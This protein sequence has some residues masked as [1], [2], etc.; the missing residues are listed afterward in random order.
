V[1]HHH[2]TGW[3]EAGDDVFAEGVVY[4]G[5]DHPAYGFLCNARVT[6]AGIERYVAF[7]TTLVAARH[8]VRR[9]HLEDAGLLEGFI[10]RLGSGCTA[11]AL[12][13]LHDDVELDMSDPAAIGHRITA[14]DKQSLVQSLESWPED[15]TVEILSS[16][17]D[18][19]ELYAEARV[20][21]TR[22][23]PDLTV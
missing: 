3:A 23:R 18:G 14:S 9:P 15:A 5:G 21:G 8:R 17:V 19:G 10:T 16:A 6:A 22:S 7:R 13:L 20:E 1:V 2:V 11:E 12:E 4:E